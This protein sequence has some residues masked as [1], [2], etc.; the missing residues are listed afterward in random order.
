MIFLT[1]GELAN[2]CADNL[3]FYI[4]VHFRMYMFKGRNIMH[5][6]LMLATMIGVGVGVAKFMK[7]K[8]TNNCENLQTQ[9]QQASA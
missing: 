9:E 8:K 6:L 3:R 5:K 1:V 2:C 7:K 4:K